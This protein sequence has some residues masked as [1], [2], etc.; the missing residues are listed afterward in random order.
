MVSEQLLSLVKRFEGCHLS[1]Y[2]CPAGVLTVGFGATGAGVFPGE[3]WTQE[4][5]DNRL[6][7]DLER[8]SQ[9]VRYLCPNLTENR[10]DAVISFAFNVGLGNLRASTLLKR[11]KAEDWPA[12]QKEIMRWNRGGGRVLAGLTRRRAA[13]AAL[14]A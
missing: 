14:L 7:S 1:P 2:I 12:A 6:K 5:A 10:L 9:G 13:E 11:L 4:Q 8:F 3:T